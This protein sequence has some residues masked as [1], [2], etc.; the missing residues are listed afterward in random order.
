MTM[1]EN[2]LSDIN[3]IGNPALLNQVYEY[4]QLLKVSKSLKIKNQAEIVKLAGS[5]SSKDAAE[6]SAIIN[7]EFNEIEGDW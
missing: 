5:L 1:K 4:L 3:S 6:I 2:I 7:D